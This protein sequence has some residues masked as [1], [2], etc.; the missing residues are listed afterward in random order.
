MQIA[1]TGQ[2][3]V[4]YSLHQS[5]TATT[6]L[7]PHLQQL[8]EYHGALPENLVADAGYGSQENYQ[9][10]EENHIAAYMKYGEFDRRQNKAI[11]DKH[12]FSTDKL[13]YNKEQDCFICPMGQKMQNRG[14]YTKTTHSGFQQ[15]IHRYEAQ[16]C[17]GC[18]LRGMCHKAKGNRVIEVNHELNQLKQ[19]A[20]ERL[21]SEEGIARRKQ[22]CWDVEPVFGNIKQN[23]HF[24]RFMLRGIKKVAIETGLLLLAHNL[25]KKA[26]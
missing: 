18:P 13:Y 19:N 16:R 7:I 21:K 15:T 26:A 12:P 14:R 11:R 6:T 4:S 10:L 20:N 1:T 25:R 2:Y 8:K 17:E 24:R 23:H 22:R 5:T 9:F 3:V